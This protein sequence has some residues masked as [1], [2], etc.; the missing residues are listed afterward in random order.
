ME[1]NNKNNVHV[2]IRVRPLISIE[3]NT[4]EVVEVQS[5]VVL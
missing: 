2:F 5:D 3:A 1:S 4:E